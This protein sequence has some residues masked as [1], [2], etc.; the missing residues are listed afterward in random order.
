M[1]YASTNRTFGA[2]STPSRI[3]PFFGQFSIKFEKMQTIFLNSRSPRMKNGVG[4]H[5]MG[6]GR[7]SSAIFI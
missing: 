2:K 3:E 1:H 4:D 7:L 5:S 6:I